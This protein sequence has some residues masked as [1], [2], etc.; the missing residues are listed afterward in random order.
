[1]NTDEFRIEEIC[2]D[3]PLSAT[4][5]LILKEAVYCNNY[6]GVEVIKHLMQFYKLKTVSLS[7][8][9][10]H[11]TTIPKTSIHHHWRLSGLKAMAIHFPRPD[12]EEVRMQVT[13]YLPS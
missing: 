11:Q 5:G 9:I 6:N 13:R 12:L 10:L 3:D 1:M 7:Q 2:P 8:Y 4:T